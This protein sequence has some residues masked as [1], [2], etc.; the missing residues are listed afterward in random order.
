MS[1]KVFRPRHWRERL[2]FYS[3][4]N[5]VKTFYFNLK[6]FPWEIA[7]KMPVFFYGPV[8]FG[9]L[10]GTISIKGPVKKAMIGFGQP[11]EILSRSKGTA[12][13]HLEGHLEFAGAAQFGKDYFVFIGT[14]ATCKMGHMASLGHSGKIICFN[15]VE[16]GDFARAGFESQIMDSTFHQ[17]IDTVTGEKFPLTRPVSIGSYNYIGHR[18]SVMPGTITP[19]RC[20][21]A[22]NSVCNKDFTFLGVNILIGGIP[23]KLLKSNISRDWEGEAAQMEQWL[24]V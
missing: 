12:L 16:M 21:V 23:A 10:E 5:W 4:V 13:L 9:S 20:T 17:M 3:K 2:K 18:V 7:K 11:Y 22:S 15:S 6:M 1:K 19:A 24:R 14:A 8:K